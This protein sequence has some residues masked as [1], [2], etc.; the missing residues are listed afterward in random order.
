MARANAFSTENLAYYRHR[1]RRRLLAFVR[2]V[3]VFYI[4]YQ[5]ISSMVIGSYAVGSIS[6]SPLLAP[7]DH[8]LVAPVVYGAPV[9]FTHL[10]LPAIRPP[11]RG[12]VVLV[13]PPYA[14]HAAWYVRVIDPV[15]TFFTGKSAGIG[16]R[17]RPQERNLLAVERVVAVPGDTV[18]VRKGSVFVKPP[19]AAS[20]SRDTKLI[21]GSYDP[22]PAALPKGWRADLPFSQSAAAVTLGPKQYFVMGDDR[23][24]S[25]GSTLWGPVTSAR[26]VG[27]VV[28]RYWPLRKLSIL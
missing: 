20:F 5:L 9:P 15:I 22:K 17:Y 24:A 13:Q 7:G 18:E 12:D 25:S 4:L 26:I 23:G 6:M 27:Q 16:P 28:L 1:T 3:I 8:V 21:G 11:R 14:P 19:G 10:R 2:F